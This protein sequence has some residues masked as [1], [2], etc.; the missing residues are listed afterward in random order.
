MLFHSTM[1]ERRGKGYACMS[2]IGCR[3][4]FLYNKRTLNIISIPPQWWLASVY[5]TQSSLLLNTA[6]WGTILSIREPWETLYR[7]DSEHEGWVTY[8]ML[9]TAKVERDRNL[10]EHSKHLTLL[11]TS[12]F[13]GR[14]FHIQGPHSTFGEWINDQEGAMPVNEIWGDQDTFQSQKPPSG[15]CDLCYT[16][17]SAGALAHSACERMLKLCCW[18]FK[19]IA[20][21]QKMLGNYVGL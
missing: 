1:E 21:N 6:T 20:T 9:R 15:S 16:V 2:P 5:T 4:C 12:V 11:H 3:I 14:A 17:A 19:S 10:I 8:S 13:S 18:I 7:F